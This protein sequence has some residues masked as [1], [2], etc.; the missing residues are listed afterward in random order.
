MKKLIFCINYCSFKFTV[1]HD[2]DDH[3]I[4]DVD[5]DDDDDNIQDRLADRLCTENGTWWVHPDSNR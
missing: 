5:N 4:D 3:D 1:D 2:H